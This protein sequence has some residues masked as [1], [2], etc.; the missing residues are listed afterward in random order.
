MYTFSETSLIYIF[1]KR[2]RIDLIE[3]VKRVARDSFIPPRIG[4]LVGATWQSI[5]RFKIP[6]TFANTSR[7]Y[8]FL[9]HGHG[10]FSGGGWRK[11][12][13]DGKAEDHR[14]FT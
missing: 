5:A 12:T 1:P 14:S 2:K 10:D 7:I 6:A 13:T 8:V 11:N 3:T 9:L 4:A